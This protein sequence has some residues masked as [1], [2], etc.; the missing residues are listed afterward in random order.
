MIIKGRPISPGIAEGK[1]SVC[2]SYISPLGEMGKDGKIKSGQCEGMEFKDRIFVFKGGR[3]STVGSY[4]LL[5]LKEDN[6]A[7]IGIINEFSE[8]VIMTGAIISE[9]PMVDSI[10]IDIFLN[11][12]KVKINGRTG[13]VDIS[14]VVIKDTVTVYLFNGNKFLLLKRSKEVSS[15]QEKYSAVSGHI[16]EGE[17]PWEAGKREIF[18]ETGISDVEFIAEGEAF[19]VRWKNVIFMVHP[20]VA[21]TNSIYAKLNW[22]NSS[23]LWIYPNDIDLYDTVP[24][25]KDPLLKILN[26]RDLRSV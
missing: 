5:E 19:P 21:R 26:A 4:V 12:D 6:V 14:D 20:I 16:E 18:E 13:D 17:T 3:G 25:L 9:I 23:Y 11:D 7:P 24:K 1:V 2:N 15:Y 10:P 8:I 22:E